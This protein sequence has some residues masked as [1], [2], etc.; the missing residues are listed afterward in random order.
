MAT[1]NASINADFSMEERCHDL[2]HNIAAMSLDAEAPA[3]PPAP[4]PAPAPLAVLPLDLDD[5]VSCFCRSAFP[6]SRAASSRP[7]RRSSGPGIVRWYGAVRRET[8]RSV[9]QSSSQSSHRAAY[10]HSCVIAAHL[11]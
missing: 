6:I 9:S 3:K 8:E 4:A 1:A 5:T 11:T 7:T 10:Q 2:S